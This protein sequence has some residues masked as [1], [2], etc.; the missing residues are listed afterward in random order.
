MSAKKIDVSALCLI[1]KLNI[2]SQLAHPPSLPSASTGPF[3]LLI[4]ERLAQSSG[5][6]HG[7]CP[8]S[9]YKKLFLGK[10]LLGLLESKF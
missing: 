8:L 9:S 7:L 3:Q 1:S 2:E 10:M 5:P 4:L 6:L